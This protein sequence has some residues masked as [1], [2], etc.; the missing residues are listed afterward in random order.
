MCCGKMRNG[1]AP[2]AYSVKRD[3]LQ[4]QKRPSTVSKETCSFRLIACISH[5]FSFSCARSIPLQDERKELARGVY[6]TGKERECFDGGEDKNTGGGG[7][8]SPLDLSWKIQE[9]QGSGFLNK[10]GKNQEDQDGSV[11]EM[12]STEIIRVSA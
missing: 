11:D 7:R 12:G 6:S 2:F 10:G 5:L 1:S 8:G 9:V 4:C 3:L